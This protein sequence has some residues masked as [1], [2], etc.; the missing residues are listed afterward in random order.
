[1][2]GLLPSYLGRTVLTALCRVCHAA[3]RLCSTVPGQGVPAISSRDEHST[4]LAALLLNE[5]RITK[6]LSKPSYH[7]IDDTRNTGGASFEGFRVLY[8]TSFIMCALIVNACE[9]IV[10]P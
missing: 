8:I 3:G 4:Q 1:M 7:M 10:V 2:K 9:G 6:E 5:A